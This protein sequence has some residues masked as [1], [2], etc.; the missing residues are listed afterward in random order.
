MTSSKCGA[1]WNLP[2]LICKMGIRKSVIFIPI[3]QT[4]KLIVRSRPSG[5]RAHMLSHNTVV[6]LEPM[7]CESSL[8]T[9]LSASRVAMKSTPREVGSL[10]RKSPQRTPED[11]PVLLCRNPIS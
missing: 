2:L 10:H 5:C 8:Q 7:S 6:L 3:L 9:L 4:R 11:S 1:S